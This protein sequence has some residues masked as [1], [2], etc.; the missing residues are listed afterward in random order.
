[1]TGQELATNVDPLIDRLI[2]Y[3]EIAMEGKHVHV[4]YAC[5]VAQYKCSCK[6]PEQGMICEMCDGEAF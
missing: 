5:G 2:T 4:C 6:H 1:M 3:V